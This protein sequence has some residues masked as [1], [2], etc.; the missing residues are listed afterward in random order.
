LKVLFG[1]LS[2]GGRPAHQRIEDC[3]DR[4]PAHLKETPVEYMLMYL[5]TAHDFAQRADPDA[6]PAY[7]GA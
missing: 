2:I 3:D 1:S 5:E 4:G 6:A 7:W